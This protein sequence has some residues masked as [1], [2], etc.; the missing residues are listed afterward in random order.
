MAEWIGLL[1]TREKEKWLL[2]FSFLST[3]FLYSL[4]K[5][6]IKNLNLDYHIR[7]H[8]MLFSAATRKDANIIKLSRIVLH[9][10]GLFKTCIIEW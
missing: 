7:I 4:V 3:N 10:Y 5:L 9:S 1:N 8:F 6:C 2:C